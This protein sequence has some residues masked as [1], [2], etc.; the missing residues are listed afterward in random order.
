MISILSY[1]AAIS[2]FWC[3]AVGMPQAH[4]LYLETNSLEVCGAPRRWIIRW[5]F[6]Q[7]TA[8]SAA[9]ERFPV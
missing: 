9:G 5:Q 2:A 3:G 6:A 1:A 8:K 7:T 4:A